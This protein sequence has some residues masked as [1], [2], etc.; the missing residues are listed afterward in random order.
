MHR[1]Y[2]VTSFLYIYYFF[3]TPTRFP[4]H[5]LAGGTQAVDLSCVLTFLIRLYNLAVFCERTWR[6]NPIV[7]DLQHLLHW[8]LFVC[9]PLC[10]HVSSPPTVSRYRSDQ[11][12]TTPWTE[13]W[14]MQPLPPNRAVFAW[15]HLFP[16][17]FKLPSGKS[18]T[19]YLAAAQIT[20]SILESHLSSACLS[21]YIECDLFLWLTELV[22]VKRRVLLTALHDRFKSLRADAPG[23][24]IK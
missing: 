15:V 1:S 5:L 24:L 21:P 19:L 20:T 6:P 16:R 11:T 3:L 12:A 9:F 4:T 22:G 23:W 18:L 7:T 2:S 17:L 10:Q 8:T 13:S 14:R